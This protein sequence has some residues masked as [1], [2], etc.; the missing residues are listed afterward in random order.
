MTLRQMSTNNNVDDVI[1]AH[2]SRDNTGRRLSRLY[3]RPGN[4]MAAGGDALL[5]QTRTC[6]AKA[7]V[8]ALLFLMSVS[9]YS[10]TFRSIR[11]IWVGTKY[12]V[13]QTRWSHAVSAALH[14]C[15]GRE[16]IS[17]CYVRLH[18]AVSASAYSDSIALY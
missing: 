17:P 6:L 4:S 3:Q 13:F 9:V 11:C 7:A 2:R 16:F 15:I 12:T 1:V 10:W 14:L 18:T 5:T 8:N